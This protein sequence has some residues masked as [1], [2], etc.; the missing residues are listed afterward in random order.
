MGQKLKKK[1][2]CAK[3]FFEAI[4]IPFWSQFFTYWE[5]KNIPKYSSCHFMPFWTQ[6]LT[7]AKLIFRS[8]QELSCLKTNTYNLFVYGELWIDNFE[9]S[10][11]RSFGV[12]STFTS[13]GTHIAALSKSSFTRSSP[14]LSVL[15]NK[16]GLETISTT[17]IARW[18]RAPLAISGICRMNYIMYH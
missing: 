11:K 9:F 8:A 18:P 6:W 15:N 14:I 7:R 13:T 10:S 1:V 12:L 4:K 17:K 3:W 16:S 5:P 2:V